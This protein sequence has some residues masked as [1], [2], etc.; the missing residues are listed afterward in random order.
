MAL[1]LQAFSQGRFLLIIAV[2]GHTFAHAAAFLTFRLVDVRDVIL[3]EGKRAEAADVLAAVC[4][5]AAAGV[6][7]FVTAH[8]ALV[9]CDLDDLDNI[10]IVAV[11]AHCDLYSVP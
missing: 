11:A 3:V 1:I 8:R 5:A 10:G 7:H 4:E 6:G 2:Y 9:A